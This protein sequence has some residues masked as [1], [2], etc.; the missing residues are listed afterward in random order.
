LSLVSGTA[1][2]FSF[3]N[4]KKVSLDLGLG[5][6][7][8]SLLGMAL[9]L[10]V[11]LV[12]KE[13][14]DRTIYLTLSRGVSRASFFIGKIFGLS[15]VLFLN[16]VILS[17]F[18]IS[19]YLYNGGTISDLLFISILFSYL[20]SIIILNV[21]SFFSLFTN[22][23]L[24][25]LYSIIVFGVGSMLNETAL[26]NYVDQRP[27]IFKFLKMLSFFLP[28]FSALNIKDYVLY[29]NNLPLSYL[30]GTILYGITYPFVLLSISCY[31]LAQK[32]LD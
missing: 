15:F 16:A 23:N 13:I 1:S 29:Q 11:N 21:V 17:I 19:I 4:P 8:L 7:N 9:F 24:S 28:N 20:S 31:I 27:I 5:L 12:S 30:I 32:D 22:I 6:M 10:G 18:V 25:V 14:R 2:S 26:L 3:G